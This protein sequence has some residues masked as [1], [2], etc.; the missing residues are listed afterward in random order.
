MPNAS[1]TPGV[2]SS[3]VTPGNIASTIC[4]TGYTSGRRLDD[5]RRV[6]PP[7]AYTS[8]LKVTQIVQ[9]GYADMSSAATRRTI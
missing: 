9:Y 4:V 3:D 7:E 5:G 8:S 2:A 6:R 1:L